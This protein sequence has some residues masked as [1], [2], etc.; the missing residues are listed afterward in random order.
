[1]RSDERAGKFIM[2]L[3]HSQTRSE[4]GKAMTKIPTQ[5]GD[6]LI[7]RTDKAGSTHAVGAISKDDQQDFKGQSDLNYVSGR[8]AAEAAARSLV[9][10][11]GRIFFRNDD[12]GDWQEISN[13]R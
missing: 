8:A 1:M 3:I 7:L 9:M 10:P 6:V 5:I 13:P 12:T 2:V 4:H 11:G